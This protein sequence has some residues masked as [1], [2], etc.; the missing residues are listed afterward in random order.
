MKNITLSILEASRVT[1][2]NIGGFFATMFLIL[3]LLTIVSVF[4]IFLKITD[5]VLSLVKTKK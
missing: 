3:S 1:L 4:G 5:A 2:A